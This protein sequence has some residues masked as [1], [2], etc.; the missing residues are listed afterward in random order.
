MVRRHVREGEAVLTRQR[1]VIDRLDFHRHDSTEARALLMTFEET[2]AEHCSHLERLLLAESWAGLI[3]T[4]FSAYAKS[5]FSNWLN[6]SRSLR[7]RCTMARLKGIVAKT[8]V[9]LTV[10]ALRPCS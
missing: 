2:Q 3:R 8:T 4:I 9:A 6:A 5:R 10:A 1:A 7:W